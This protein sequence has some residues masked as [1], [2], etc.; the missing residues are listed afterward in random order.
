MECNSGSNYRIGSITVGARL[1]MTE[2]QFRRRL[3]GARKWAAA[4]PD[5][6]WSSRA[7]DFE[8]VAE[9]LGMIAEAFAPV[10]KTRR[11]L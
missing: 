8:G 3:A 9:T 11:L 7:A 5:G 6:K 4:H 10:W 2:A 1:V